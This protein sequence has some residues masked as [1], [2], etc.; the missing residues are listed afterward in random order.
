[1][2][3]LRIYLAPSQ[4]EAGFVSIAH[5]SED[6]DNTIAEN[7]EAM[8]LRSH[9]AT[10]LRACPTKSR[11]RRLFLLLTV[12]ATIT[13]VK[14]RPPVENGLEARGNRSRSGSYRPPRWCSDP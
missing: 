2:L 10:A 4:F 9:S 8:R 7:R 3:E 5:T 6:I 11:E 12:I 14:S 1:M 13:E